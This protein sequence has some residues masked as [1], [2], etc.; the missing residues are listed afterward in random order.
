MASV[1]HPVK[2]MIA[3]ELG[4]NCYLIQFFHQMDLD[5]I[6]KHGPWTFSNNPILLR[7]LQPNENPRSVE[8]TRLEMWVQLHNLTSDF[9]SK[10]V[11]HDFGDY[12]SEYLESDPKNYPVTLSG[13]CGRKDKQEDEDC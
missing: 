8:V 4:N 2:G 13:R 7:E 11:G 10:R 1:W 6:M 9:F 5:R 3:K 12:I